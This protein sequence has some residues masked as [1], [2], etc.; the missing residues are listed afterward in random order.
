MVAESIG[1]TWI[2]ISWDS[3]LGIVSYNVTATGDSGGVS[4][5]VKS[6]DT[7]V[8]VTGLQPGT[9][10]TLTVVSVS[11]NKEVSPPSDPL[12]AMTL[13][14]PGILCISDICYS[15]CDIQVRTN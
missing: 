2:V 14:R 10:Y 5:V 9:E 4:V 8:N 3:T 13:L 6:S 1:A 12:I 11:V 15:R 7:E